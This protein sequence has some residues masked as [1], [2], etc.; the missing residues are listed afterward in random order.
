MT[1]DDYILSHIDPEGDY[2]YR[3][4]RAT[5]VHLLHGRMASG[6]LQGRLLKMIVTMIRPKNILEVGTFSGYSAI[7]MAEGLEEGGRLYTFEINDEMEDFTRTWLE[8]S[9]VADK[10]DFRIGDAN[11]E[12][13]RLGI[14]F[15][16]AFID[17]DKRTYLETYEMVLRILRPGG[18]ILADNILWDGHVLEQAKPADRQTQGIEAFN[19]YVA[20]DSRVE[21]VILPIRDGLTIIRK[22]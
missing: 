6:H 12:A 4:W 1:L 2:L 14:E 10:I 13:P 21:R 7:C 3:L 16:M 8:G 18:F 20:R 5:N 11:V 9:A 17:G 15:D 19:D 22:L